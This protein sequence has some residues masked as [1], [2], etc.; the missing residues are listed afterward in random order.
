MVAPND[1]SV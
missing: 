1:F